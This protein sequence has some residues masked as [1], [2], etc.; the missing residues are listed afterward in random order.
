MRCHSDARNAPKKQREVMALQEVV[1]LDTCHRERPSFST[2][3]A[4]SQ[5]MT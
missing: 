2:G 5:G 1:V 4:I 3:A